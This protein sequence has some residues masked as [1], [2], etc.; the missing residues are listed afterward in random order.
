MSVVQEYPSREDTARGC[1]RAAM[2]RHTVGT[3][4]DRSRTEVSADS[5]HVIGHV[6]PIERLDQPD[7]PSRTRLHYRRCA[8]AAM[9]RLAGPKR[10]RTRPRADD[11]PLFRQRSLTHAKL[12][13][14]FELAQP[15]SDPVGCDWLSL[16]EGES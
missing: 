13:V 9:G 5:K 11:R 8:M 2:G 15:S 14:G 10:T 1:T 7:F 3:E 6:A 12:R 16:G 4:A